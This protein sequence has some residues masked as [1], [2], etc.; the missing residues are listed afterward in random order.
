M[1][2]KEKFK[3]TLCNDVQG[4]LALYEA[5]YL[6]VEGEQVLDEALEFTKTHLDIIE[7]DPSCDSL[8]KTEIH[9][10]LKQPLWK[11]LPRLEAVRY[12]PIYQQKTT[13]S[14]VLLKLAKLN[15]NILQSM[16]KKELSQLCK[17]WKDLD[18]QNKLPY[19]RDRLVEG[20]FWILG[21][22]FEPE[23]SHTRM[24]L[25]KSCV[26]LVVIDDTFDN[27]GTYEELE[28]F[29][30]AVQRWSISCMDMLPEYMKLI[31]QHLLNHHQ[32]MEESLEKNGKSYQIHHVTE[33]VR[34][35]FVYFSSLKKLKLTDYVSYTLI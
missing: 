12:I 16:Q 28:I 9:Q 4:L 35:F 14:E 20:Y 33:M 22:Y 6:R 2:E 17:W 32:E 34:E 5:T 13:H 26:W 7:K 30:E 15:F 25:T 3:E 23:H 8:S 18:L 24:F 21:I 27:Y 11:T 31:Y 10:A 29:T 19:V 1:D